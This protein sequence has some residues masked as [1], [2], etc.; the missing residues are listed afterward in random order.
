L[1]HLLCHPHALEEDEP[2]IRLPGVKALVHSPHLTSLT[3]LRLRLSDMG[4]AGIQEIVKS[5]ILKR[6]KVLDLRNGLV[7]DDGARALAGCADLR[8][9]ESLDLS[10]N[11]L[12]D[13]GIAALKKTGI[14]VAADK[15]WQG[16]DQE[17][18]Y[19]GDIE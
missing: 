11:R 18:L 15:Q 5:G 9:L 16:D 13:A 19:E 12:T 14:Q 17:Y 1:T 4:D 7:T 2:Y 6:L 10:R 8:N 3:H